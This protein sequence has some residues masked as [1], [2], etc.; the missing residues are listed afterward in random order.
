[1]IY[2]D[3]AASTSVD[4]EVLSSYV[5]FIKE[6]Y[7]NSASVHGFGQKVSVYEA[8]ARKQIADLFHKNE[9]EIIFTSGASE[10]NN[11][12]IKGS[13]LYYKNRGKHLITSTIEH[14]SV[15]NAFKQLEEEF[16]FEVTY[17]QPNQDGIITSSQVENAIKKDT[18]LVSLMYVNNEIGSIND[19]P[20]ISKMLKKYPKIIFHCDATQAIGKIETNFTYVDL[21]SLSLHKIHGFKGSGILLKKDS[22]SLLSLIS[23]GGQEFNFRSGT[24]N[25]PYEVSA[26]KC[27]RIALSKQKENYKKVLELHNF[28]IK[29][30]N[31]IKGIHINSP[32]NGSP[33][34]VNFSVN[35]KASVVV[36]ALSNKDIYISTK[37]ACSSKKTSLSY[38]L[39]EIGLDENIA[40]NALRISFSH[41]NTIEEVK[42]F[43]HTLDDILKSI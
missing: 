22:L 21:I 26:A 25:V 14:A 35:K 2:F 34:I 9:N 6:N 11:L 18:I 28:L 16:D 30:L 39:T 17:L 31:K 32:L 24:N 41:L 19:I 36:E 37:S 33:F 29:G 20:N 5:K 42:I 8:K 4:E 38:V 15:L 23:G 13:A 7:A 10:S 27:I 40:S 1:M 3:N 43:L 12:A